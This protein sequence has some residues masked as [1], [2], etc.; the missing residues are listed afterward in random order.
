ME[1]DVPLYKTYLLFIFGFGGTD[2]KN[3]TALV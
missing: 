3:V 2:W 1:I